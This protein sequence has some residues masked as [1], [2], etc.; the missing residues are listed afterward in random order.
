MIKNIE[1][2]GF[3]SFVSDSIDLN[4]LTLLT[5]IN[6]SGKSSV[7]QALLLL[8]KAERQRNVD[9]LF[10]AGHGSL[11]ELKNPYVSNG[12]DV[13]AAFEGGYNIGFHHKNGRL[14]RIDIGGFFPLTTYIAA[15]RFGPETSIPIIYDSYKLGSKGENLFKCIDH[16]ADE[17]M[18]DIVVHEN[19]EGYTFLFNLRAWLGVISPNVDFKYEIQA[20]SDSSFSRFNGHRSKNVGFG[21]SYTLPI[22]TALLAGTLMPGSLVLI[23][24]PEAHL[25]PRG[26][27][28]MARLICKCVEAGVQVVVETHSDHL[29]NGIRIYAK[30][31][32]N[33]FNEKVQIHW[34]ELDKNKN[35]DVQSTTIAPDGRL[36][37]WP[38]GLFDQFE[39]NANQ[40]L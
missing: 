12:I 21:L 6:S 18:S 35:T 31:S 14:E 37:E 29:L 4:Q 25:H 39:I 19:S 17:T 10:L 11:E 2:N 36:Y 15:D 5:G 33:A 27:T 26:Q 1:L 13:I 24:N 7:I 34:F 38:V 28:E 16:Y 30:K 20:Q 3:K 40:L 9:A 23:E 22:I 32:D 8:E